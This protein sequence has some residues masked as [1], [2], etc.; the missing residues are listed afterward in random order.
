[1]RGGNGTTAKVAQSRNRGGD[2]RRGVFQVVAR[3]RTRGR[4]SFAERI[5]Y[6]R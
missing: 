6:A 2:S 1:L 5:I 4:L 3:T